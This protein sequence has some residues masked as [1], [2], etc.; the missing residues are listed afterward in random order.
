MMNQKKCR[1]KKKIQNNKILKYK[2]MNLSNQIK[3]NKNY[4]EKR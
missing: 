3:K 1:F 4:E 2:I